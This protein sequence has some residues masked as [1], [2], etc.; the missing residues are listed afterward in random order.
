MD[1]MDT[2]YGTPKVEVN[3]DMTVDP[4]DRLLNILDRIEAH[5][6]DLRRESLRLEER[7]DTLFTTLDTIRNSEHLNNLADTDKD[8]IQ[9]Y[10]ERIT[11]RCTTV[12]ISVRT[13]RD[14]QQ[15][16][17]L[18]QV[19]K[20]IDN[21]VIAFKS[22]PDNSMNKCQSFLAAC[23]DEP[24]VPVDKGFESALLGCALDDQKRIKKRLHGLLDYL[25]E[26]RFTFVSEL[27]EEKSG[28]CSPE[29][30]CFQTRSRYSPPLKR[31]KRDIAEDPY[32]PLKKTQLDVPSLLEGQQSAI[33][34]LGK[35]V[36]DL[37][38]SLQNLTEE[39]GRIRHS[40]EDVLLALNEKKLAFKTK[41]VNIASGEQYQ[42]W[43]LEVNPRGEVPAIKD[44]NKTIP[45]SMKIINYL[46]ENYSDE[47]VSSEYVPL[48]DE[49]SRENKNKK[50]KNHSKGG[51]ENEVH[52]TW[53]ESRSQVGQLPL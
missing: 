5:V 12:E 53:K 50:K 35:N 3:D 16:E 10:I 31:I 47:S 52:G 24:E 18:Y 45:D 20:M 28:N 30:T 4:K 2:D 19:N 49:E 6:E 21:L 44:G 41:F 33:D 27:K 36:Q 26:G 1:V 40:Y 8:D 7:K 38:D 13:D 15:E 23:K 22:D 51:K 39:L 32:D 25:G 14:K 46:E 34:S 37:N 48:K 17:S 43:Y 29:A 9:R 42:Q 11:A